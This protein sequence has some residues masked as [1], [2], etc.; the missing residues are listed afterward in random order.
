MVPLPV[1][2]TAL[3]STVFDCICLDAGGNDGPHYLPREAAERMLKG[4]RDL[5]QKSQALLVHCEYVRGETSVCSAPIPRGCVTPLGCDRLPP[6]ANGAAI[7]AGPRSCSRRR[8]AST[9]AEPDA[10]PASR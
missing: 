9:A 8:H 5:A 1:G 2:K 6:P 10:G 3:V 4:S 7:R